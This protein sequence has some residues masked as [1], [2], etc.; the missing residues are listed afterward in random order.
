LVF[1]FKFFDFF[2]E[3]KERRARTHNLTLTYGTKNSIGGHTLSSP[4]FLEVDTKVSQPFRSE[5]PQEEECW[6]AAGAVARTGITA[7]T[8]I[9][10]AE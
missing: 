1:V 8:G 7:G 10:G 4:T 5:I 9:R 3:H 6:G 2:Q